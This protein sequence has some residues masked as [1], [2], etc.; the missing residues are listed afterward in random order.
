MAS[1][2]L[3]KEQ[4]KNKKRRQMLNRERKIKRRRNL[5]MKVFKEPESEKKP[6]IIHE[7][8]FEFILAD[9]KYKRKIIIETRRSILFKSFKR[10]TY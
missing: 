7:D 6:F 4:L 10:Q 5:I 1:K 3:S 2:K 8:T 9:E